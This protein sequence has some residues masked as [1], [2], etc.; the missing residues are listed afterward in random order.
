MEKMN[1]KKQRAER[2]ESNYQS[3]EKLSGFAFTRRQAVR[4]PRPMFQPCSD[5][6]RNDCSDQQQRLADDRPSWCFHL[7]T[8]AQES[9]QYSK[10]E[11][12]QQNHSN[13]VEE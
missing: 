6:G 3:G 7:R 12:L 13:Y 2:N 5:E 11:R 8:V 10:E 1:Q 4:T 9:P